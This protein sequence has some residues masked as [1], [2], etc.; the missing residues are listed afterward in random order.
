MSTQTPKSGSSRTVVSLVAGVA[1]VA[2]AAVGALL[3]LGGGDDDKAKNATA[4]AAAGKLTRFDGPKEAPF[5]LTVP[6]G[7]SR[8]SQSAVEKDGLENGIAVKRNDG[9]AFITLKVDGPVKQGLN[10]LGSDL[11]RDLAE[12]FPGMKLVASKPI[13]VA[14]GRALYTSWTQK[15]KAAVQSNL[16][17]PAGDI[18]Y[19]LDAVFN[20]TS[21]KAA[22]EVGVVL[23]AFDD[24]N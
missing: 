5:Q 6:A 22:Q 12:R 11:K 7:W 18:S 13:N 9:S 19:Q 2:L 10:S 16:V 8:V 24:K 14:A 15:D 17:V 3:L 20:G 4:T 1:V 23:R 21:D